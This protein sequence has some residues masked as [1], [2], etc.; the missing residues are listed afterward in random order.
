ATT[1]ILEIAQGWKR[2]YETEYG[3]PVWGIGAPSYPRWSRPRSLAS[4]GRAVW[5]FRRVVRE[6]NPDI[7]HVHYPLSQALVVSTARVAGAN[8]RTVVTLHGS[9]IRV[10]PLSAPELQSWQA[11]LLR[12]ADSVTAVDGSLLREAGERYPNLT[13]NKMVIPNG[14]GQEWLEQLPAK[15]DEFRPYVLFVGRLHSVKGADLLL[16]AWKELS[17]RYPSLKLRLVGDGP[18]RSNLKE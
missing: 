15:D 18:E 11:R 3:I 6:F 9:D 4:L 5:Q 13:K 8:W 10:S 12:L 14:I 17:P 16:H 2:R 7:V 1:A